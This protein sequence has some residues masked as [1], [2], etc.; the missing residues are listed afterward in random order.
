MQHQLHRTYN[1]FDFEYRI[2]TTLIANGYSQAASHSQ[3]VLTVAKEA[4]S[5]F[6]KYYTIPEQILSKILDYSEQFDL[7][8]K[9]LDLHLSLHPHQIYPH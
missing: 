4:I 5:T 3:Q 7:L 1:V 2:A 8:E 6:Q 9:Y